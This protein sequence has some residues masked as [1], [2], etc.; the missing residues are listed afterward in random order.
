VLRLDALLA[1]AEFCPGA[2]LFEGVQDVFH[3]VFPVKFGSVLTRPFPA[4]KQAS[5]ASL[6]IL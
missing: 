2:E 3:V 1:A 6:A 4:G 5:G